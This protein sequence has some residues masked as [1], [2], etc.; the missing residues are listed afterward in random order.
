MKQQDTPKTPIDVESFT[1]NNAPSGTD[2]KQMAYQ[3]LG[4]NRL[5][6][7]VGN[8]SII[9][10]TD[11]TTWNNAN[12]Y[13]NLPYVAVAP[14][15]NFFVAIDSAGNVRKSGDG[16]NWSSAGTLPAG[17]YNSLE[18]GDGYH[19]A[20]ANSDSNAYV[21]TNNG[22]TWATVSAG[23]SNVKF[24]AYGNGK[25]IAMNEAGDTWESTDNAQT[26]TQGPDL[27]NVQ[28]DVASLCF[29]NGRF[30]AAAYDS[31]NDIS[32]VN[33]KFF[34]S[35]TNKSTAAGNTVW[36]MGEDT[37]AADNF[38]VSYAQGVFVAVS[39]NGQVCVSPDGNLWDN[40]SSLGGAYNG[41]FAGSSRTGGPQFFPTQNGTVSQITTIEYGATA[42]IIPQIVS[43]RISEFTIVEAGSGYTGSAPTL[44]IVD[45]DKTGS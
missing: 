5:T 10:T 39:A 13:T 4:S 43:N 44:S 11:G 36:L 24:L 45:P 29:G 2:I 23:F 16:T 32:T 34:Y 15:N 25:W 27:G 33:N 38:Y 21:S 6:V 35:L 3:K 37:P 19:V 7:G 28:Y 20:L 18:Y 17:T 41:I 42:R 14:G 8:N 26:W 30:V 31:P 40:K 22:D 1:H 9:W 12:S